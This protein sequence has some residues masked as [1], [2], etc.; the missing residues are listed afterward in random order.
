MIAQTN[1]FKQRK[2]TGWGLSPATWQGWVYILAL[3]API[4]ILESLPL[5][6]QNTKRIFTIVWLAIASVD[7]V[8]I[9]I[10]MKKDEREVLHEAIAERNVAWFLI[11]SL[12][13]GLVYRTHTSS[14]SGQPSIDLYLLLPLLGATIVKA[15]TNLYLRDK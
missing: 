12:A 13:I 1:W 9:M 2:Y 7:V 5:F 6:D 8:D 15:V 14:L 10:R 4:M 11:L 3:V